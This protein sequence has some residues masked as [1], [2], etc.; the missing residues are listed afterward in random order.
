MV[1]NI[2][3][4]CIALS[5]IVREATPWEQPSSASKTIHPANSFEYLFCCGSGSESRKGRAH[6][7]NRTLYLYSKPAGRGCDP[8][9]KLNYRET[10]NESAWVLVTE[11]L[12]RLANSSWARTTSR[13]CHRPVDANHCSL[14]S[15]SFH[16]SPTICRMISC[17]MPKGRL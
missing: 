13:N 11:L 12:I 4:L 9:L 15:V 6:W 3:Y 10:K 7:Q 2:V 5:W 16:V 8:H 17:V 14:G 1:L